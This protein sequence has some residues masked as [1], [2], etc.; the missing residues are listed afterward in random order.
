MQQT[1]LAHP[2][3]SLRIHRRFPTEVLHSSFEAIVVET[4]ISEMLRLPSPVLG[5]ELT[6]IY[7]LQVPANVLLPAF[8]G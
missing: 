8:R 4:I 2:S 6:A 7:I 5:P 1:D 3:W